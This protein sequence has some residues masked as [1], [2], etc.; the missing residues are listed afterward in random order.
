[1][2]SRLE[3]WTDGMAAYSWAMEGE[4]SAS[5][6]FDIVVHLIFAHLLLS[7][8]VLAAPSIEATR[9]HSTLAPSHDPSLE[10]LAQQR[11]IRCR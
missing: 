1:M 9:P 10:L 6:F 2:V 4:L 5:S 8:P 11:P 3:G 7:L